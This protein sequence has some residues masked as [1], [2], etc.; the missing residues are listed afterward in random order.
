MTQMDAESKRRIAKTISDGIKNKR[1][2]AGLGRDIRK[3][4]DSMS[5][6]RGQLIAR[7]ET[8]NAL[9]QASLDRM[10]DMGIEGKEWITAGDLRVSPECIGNEGEG[11]IPRNQ[12]F[13]GGTMAPPQHPACRCSL[14]PAILKVKKA[15]PTKARPPTK[16]QPP[17]K[18]TPK[19]PAKVKPEGQKWL[20]SLP[21]EEREA[22][23]GW[24]GGS[25]QI[26]AFQ[27]TGKGAPRFKADALNIENA[28]NKAQPHKGQVFRGV[29]DL[30]SKTYNLIKSQKTFK[31][32]ALSS[33]STDNRIGLQFAQSGTTDRGGVL[34][35]IANK[36]GVDI[37]KVNPAFSFEKEVILRRDVIYEVISRK[38]ITPFAGGKQKVLEIVL[39]EI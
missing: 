1:G 26:R 34:F 17:T 39:K 24:Q 8:A 20:K 16:A 9:S 36:S 11:V 33:S 29:S 38:E 15:P 31:W 18:P 14:A 3:T 27:K 2:V 10:K 23:K 5:V 7:T 12:T 32:D 6:Y 37:S 22:L 4:F 28:L 13:S 35:R 19:A 21:K 30:D 25:R